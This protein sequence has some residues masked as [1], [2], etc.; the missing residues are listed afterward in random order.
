MLMF[1]CFFFSF[2]HRSSY[3]THLKR[4]SAPPQVTLT[5][6]LEIRSVNSL[7]DEVSSTSRHFSP[8]S[9]PQLKNQPTSQPKKPQPQTKLFEVSTA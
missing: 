5:P 4:S 2:L 8:G 7:S 9:T 6:I 3:G 1:C